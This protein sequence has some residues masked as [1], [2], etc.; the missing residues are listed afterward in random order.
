MNHIVRLNAAAT[1]GVEQVGGKA[2][3]LGEL[4]EHH[5]VPDGFVIV[6]QAFVEHFERHLGIGN[7]AG[8]EPETPPNKD[9]L[10]RLR[11]VPLDTDLARQVQDAF[12][13]LPTVDGR[14]PTCVVRSSAV[15]EDGQATSFAGQHATYYYVERADVEQRIIDCWLSSW[16][17]EVQ[18]EWL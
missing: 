18:C 11:G 3:T 17:D 6:T 7:V 13:A 16:S 12:A 8:G 14:S 4:A 5:N 2:A 9:T 1:R 10:A 15:G